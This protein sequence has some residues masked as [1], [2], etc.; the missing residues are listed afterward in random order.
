MIAPEQQ[1]KVPIPIKYECVFVHKREFVPSTAVFTTRVAR[2][3]ENTVHVRFEVLDTGI[4]ISPSNQQKL[5]TPYQQASSSTWE[6]YSGTGLGVHKS[7]R[8]RCSYMQVFLIVSIV[9][10]NENAAEFS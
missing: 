2:H 4:G 5:F 8:N 6:N 3:P 10:R 7:P 1:K 9:H